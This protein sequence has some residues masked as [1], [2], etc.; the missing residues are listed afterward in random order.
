M[1]VKGNQF[2]MSEIN[3]DKRINYLLGALLKRRIITAA[4]TLGYW[5]LMLAWSFFKQ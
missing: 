2:A 5:T 1:E 4:I 3:S